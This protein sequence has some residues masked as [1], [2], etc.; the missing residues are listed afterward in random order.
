VPIAPAMDV[1]RKT[2]DFEARIE[3]L[4][5]GPIRVGLPSI[6]IDGETWHPADLELHPMGTTLRPMPFNC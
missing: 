1:L 6:R 4:P 3:N 5:S 2:H